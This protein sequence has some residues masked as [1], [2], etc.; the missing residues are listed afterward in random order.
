[1]EE[2]WRDVVGYEGLYQVSDAGRVRSLNFNQQKGNV[3]LLKP[4]ANTHGYLQVNLKR[5]LYAVARLVAQ[6]FIPPIDDK[7][8]VD[9]IDR[10]KSNNRIENLRWADRTD[11]MVNRGYDLGVTGERNILFRN[12]R[13]HLKV[14]RNYITY[15][16]SFST[17]PEAVVARDNYL[18]SI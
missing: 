16:A 3:Q 17:L 1:M 14:C 11:Q 8:E 10:D 15:T 7:S 9:H 18:A 2:Q 6:A 12:G 5:R 4:Q 13:Y